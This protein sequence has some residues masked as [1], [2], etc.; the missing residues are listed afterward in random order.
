MGGREGEEEGR[1]ENGGV[2]RSLVAV[3]RSLGSVVRKRDFSRD[4]MYHLER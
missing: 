1:N 3:E 4:V 2:N